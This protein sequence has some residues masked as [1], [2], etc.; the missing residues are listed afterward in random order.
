LLN[1]I[2]SDI[3]LE[4]D[5]L[6]KSKTQIQLKKPK[7]ERG[8]IYMKRTFTTNWYLHKSYFSS[9]IEP[10]DTNRSRHAN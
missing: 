6:Y 4:T 5:I 8:E 3:C 2:R 7:K 1:I 9:N 10:Q